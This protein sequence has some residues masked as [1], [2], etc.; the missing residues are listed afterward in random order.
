MKTIL[1]YFFFFF[2][3]TV[4]LRSVLLFEPSRRGLRSWSFFPRDVCWGL[5]VAATPAGHVRPL[6]SGHF[7]LEHGTLPSIHFFSPPLL[8]TLVALVPGWAESWCA[9]HHPGDI[10]KRWV[11]RALITTRW[12]KPSSACIFKSSHGDADFS[13]RDY[14]RPQRKHESCTGHFPAESSEPG[15]RDSPLTLGQRPGC[16]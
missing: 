13:F 4:L 7:I 16:I 14:Q 15:S 3:C 2:N 10:A 5:S 6:S 11:L 1:F 12:K 9:T 8:S